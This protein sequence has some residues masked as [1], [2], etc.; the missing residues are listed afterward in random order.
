L[1]QIVK[2]TVE[3]EFLTDEEYPEGVLNDLIFKDPQMLAG[4]I[5]SVSL[6]IEEDKKNVLHVDFSNP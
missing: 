3:G 2:F 4:F 5:E 1:T 6:E